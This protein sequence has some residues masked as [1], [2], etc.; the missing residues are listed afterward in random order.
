MSA[1]HNLTMALA[2]EYSGVGGIAASA[3]G[4]SGGTHQFALGLPAASVVL[5][6]CPAS[7]CPAMP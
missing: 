1:Q 4:G 5:A 3:G 6:S 7:A 2:R